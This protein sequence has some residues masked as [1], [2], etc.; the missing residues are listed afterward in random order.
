MITTIK[1]PDHLVEQLQQQAIARHRSVE[2]LVIEYIEAALSD[3]TAV[4]TR[5]L[6]HS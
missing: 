3:D 2:A 1:L 6:R 5:T 4:K